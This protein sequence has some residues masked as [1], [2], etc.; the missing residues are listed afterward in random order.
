MSLR[1]LLKVPKYGL[2]YFQSDNSTS[3]VPTKKIK[4]VISGDNTS[5]GSKVI[6]QYGKE[7]LEATIIGVAGEIPFKKRAFLA[8]LFSYHL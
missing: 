6:L 1:T 3:I 5:K 2:F 4:K 8:I 7:E